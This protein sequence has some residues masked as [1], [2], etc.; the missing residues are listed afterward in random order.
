M[1]NLMAVAV[2]LAALYVADAY[3]CSG[4]YFGIATQVVENAYA[5]NW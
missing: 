3:W 1:K 4:R 5:V 2:C